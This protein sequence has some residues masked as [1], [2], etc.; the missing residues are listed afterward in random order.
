LEFISNLSAC[1]WIITNIYAPCTPQ[2]KIDFLSWLHNISMPLDKLWLLVGDFNLIR[3]PEDRNK[4]GGDIN[5]IMKFNEATSNLDLV[6]ISF[7]GLAY[8][9]SNK[10]QEPLLQ[11]LD[12][13]FISQEWSIVYPNTY[14]KTMSRD[15]SDHV[16]CLVSFKSKIPNPKIF[17]FE[18]FWLEF[19]GFMNIFQTTWLRLPCLPDKA[20]NLIAKFKIVRKVLK[21]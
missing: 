12:W 18:S 13:F 5:L 14:A 6:E 16:P 9:W 8:T 15:I 17:R 21:D 2:G 7:H 20:K 10:Q 19:D 1:S 11:R 4:A 3:R